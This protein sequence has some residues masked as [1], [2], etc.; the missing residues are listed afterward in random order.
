MRITPEP[1]ATTPLTYVVSDVESSPEGAGVGAGELAA[2]GAGENGL[3][4]GAGVET[5]GVTAGAE[6]GSTMAGDATQYDGDGNGAL[7]KNVHSGVNK[8]A[9]RG[10]VGSHSTK[11]IGDMSE[12]RVCC[13]Y[14]QDAEGRPTRH[15]RGWAP[16]FLS[17]SDYFAKRSKPRTQSESP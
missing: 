1:E 4:D 11:G 16:P 6:V 3:K 2:V 14:Q 9:R 7:V 13:I 15:G 5:G 12:R 8:E 17:F 10:T